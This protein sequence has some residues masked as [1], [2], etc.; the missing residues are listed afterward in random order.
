MRNFLVVSVAAL[1]II[2]GDWLLYSERMPTRPA[3]GKVTYKSF[4]PVAH[5]RLMFA[6]EDTHHWVR[7]AVSDWAIDENEGIPAQILVQKPGSCRLPVPETGTKLYHAHVGRSGWEA[8]LYNIRRRDVSKRIAD[9][10]NSRGSDEPPQV[11]PPR[12]GV[13][14]G[15][16]DVIVTDTQQPLH[17]V[18]ANDSETVWN[19]QL[20]KGVKLSSVTVLSRSAAGVANLPN[21]VPLKILDGKALGKCGITLARKPHRRWSAMNRKSNSYNKDSIRVWRK[22]YNKYNAWFKRQFG[23]SASENYIAASRGSHVLIGPM[24]ATLESRFPYKPL[25][26]S[27]VKV[28]PTGIFLAGSRS[29]Y[30]AAYQNV[31]KSLLDRI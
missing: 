2:G 14:M 25:E 7:H 3:Q 19:I 18:L 23:V 17:L 30:E 27:V 4:G 5:P 29:D 15:L 12:R 6:P 16:I 9:A 1:A 28:V 21:D 10:M 31:V 8:S 13:G 26:D 24:P 20:A 11:N 22:R